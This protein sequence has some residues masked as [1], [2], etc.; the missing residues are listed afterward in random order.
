MKQL[1]PAL[2][3]L[4]FTTLHAAPFSAPPTEICQWMQQDKFRGALNYSANKS[5][6]YRCTSLR[7]NINR[8]EPPKSDVRFIAQGT[9]TA[10]TTVRLEM[11]MRS[12]RKPQQA[13]RKFR[14]YAA[15][16]AATALSA[17]LP[18]EAGRS[19]MS[20]T[21][22]EWPVAGRII[23]LERVQDRGNTYDYYFRIL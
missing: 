8:G 17:E 1:F 11:R 16:L 6:L 23:K 4:A 19:L 18:E 13:L 20:G 22:G 5:G 3:L 12:F 10:V 2:L 14:E 7:R 15:T 9:Q 21:V